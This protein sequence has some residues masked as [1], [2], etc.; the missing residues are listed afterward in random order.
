MERILSED[1]GLIPVMLDIVT[2]VA[3]ASLQGPIQRTTPDAGSGILKV[4]TWE[5]VS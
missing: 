3:A 1:V 2:N 5:W 4:W